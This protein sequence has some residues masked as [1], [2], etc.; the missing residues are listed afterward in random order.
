MPDD[1]WTGFG[2]G[3]TAFYR[4]LERDNSKAFWEKHRPDFEEQVRAPMAELLDSLPDTYQPF[5]V[6]RP[7]R[8]VRFSTDKSPYKTQHGATHTTADGAVF[9]VHLDATGLM[10]AAG[11]YQLARDQLARFR[12]AVDEPVA[13][14]ELER[15]VDRAAESGLDVGPGME[16]PLRTAPRGFSQDHERIELLRWKGCITAARLDADA[17]TTPDARDWVIDVFERSQPLVDWLERRVGASQEWIDHDRP[18]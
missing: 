12:R 3:A 18:R 8:D 16:S 7:Y 14:G 5:K 6:F 4:K 13:G 9:Y 15:I 10:A 11:M 2:P 1:T 17:A